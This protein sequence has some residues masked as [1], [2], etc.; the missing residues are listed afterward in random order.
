MQQASNLAFQ[1]ATFAIT[2]QNRA[3]LVSANDNIATSRLELSLI[4]AG[5]AAQAEARA[6]LASYLDLK[7]QAESNGLAFDQAHYE[8]LKGQNRE[9]ALM[10]ELTA[11]QQLATELDNDRRFMGMSGR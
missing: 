3:R 10:V 4:G 8:L 6:N 9:L 1:Q 2:E 11:R 5:A 7:R